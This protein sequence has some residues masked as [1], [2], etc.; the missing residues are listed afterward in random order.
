MEVLGN[1]RRAEESATDTGIL[2][3]GVEMIA[4]G[5]EKR[6]SGGNKPKQ[7]NQKIMLIRTPDDRFH[8]WTVQV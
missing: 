5:G 2:Y 8:A 4:S 1:P 3:D 6:K 7:R